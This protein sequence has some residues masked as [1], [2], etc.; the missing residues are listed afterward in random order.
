MVNE[1][2]LIP[3][4]E[5][6]ELKKEIK[7]LKSHIKNSS[8]S[9]KKQEDPTNQL[10]LAIK[11]LTLVF[12][13]AVNELKKEDDQ[14]SD[15]SSD[16][17]KSG[18]EKRNSKHSSQGDAELN[19]KINVLIDQNNKIAKGIVA[20]ADLLENN[21]QKLTEGLLQQPKIKYIR[22]PIPPQTQGVQSNTQNPYAQYPQQNTPPQNYPYPYNN[23]NQSV[24]QNSNYNQNVNSNSTM[25]AKPIQNQQLSNAQLKGQVIPKAPTPI[26]QNTPLKLKPKKKRHILNF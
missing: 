11:E 22:I 10:I 2:E 12:K 25:Q 1:Y 15:N 6:S 26:K 7:E 3:E 18:K 14:N 19:E 23:P 9:S 17:S 20:L 4:G 8:N 21:L 16:G 13:Q 5:I 24:M